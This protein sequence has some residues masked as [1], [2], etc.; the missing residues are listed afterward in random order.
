MAADASSNDNV[1]F[2]IHAQKCV[3]LSS[4]LQGREICDTVFPIGSFRGAAR[5]LKD[6]MSG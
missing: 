2:H 4:L 6:H 1:V 3:I 5:A